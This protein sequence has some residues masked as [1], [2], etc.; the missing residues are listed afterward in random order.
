MLLVTDFVSLAFTAEGRRVSDFVLGVY[1][2]DEGSREQME[3]RI[4]D[5]M[6]LEEIEELAAL[7]A[8][9]TG[10]RIDNNPLRQLK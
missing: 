3:Q 6:E 8:R 7:R 5:R 9:M 1:A 10:E 4:E 2:Y